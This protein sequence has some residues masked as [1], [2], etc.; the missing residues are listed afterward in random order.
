M[1]AF[2]GFCIVFSVPDVNKGLNKYLLDKH[3]M[4]DHFTYSTLTSAELHWS[5]V[6]Y[7]IQAAESKPVFRGTDHTHKKVEGPSVKLKNISFI[8]KSFSAC[9]LSLNSYYF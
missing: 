1:G 3:L 9:I 5:F 4:K 6:D 7:V 8:S 2:L